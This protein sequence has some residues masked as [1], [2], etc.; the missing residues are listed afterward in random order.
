[1]LVEVLGPRQR[2]SKVREQKAEN[3]EE[4][5]KKETK[6]IEKRMDERR[7]RTRERGKAKPNH[8][9]VLGRRG[10]ISVADGAS[11]RPVTEVD[12]DVFPHRAQVS[13]ATRGRNTPPG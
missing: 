6:G 9:L 7:A 10:N 8:S 12:R 1:M 5:R 13:S 4:G 2:L 3:G 11:R